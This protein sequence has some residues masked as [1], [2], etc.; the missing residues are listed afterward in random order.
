MLVLV[1]LCLA[2]RKRV[3]PWTEDLNAQNMK[4]RDVV[5]AAITGRH[6]SHA[7]AA[8]GSLQDLESA[9]IVIPSP[10]SGTKYWSYRVREDGS[11]RLAF[12][13]S[14]MYPCCYYDSRFREW[15]VDA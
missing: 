9:G 14:S 8:P 4:N 1:A 2:V 15:P 12:G 11:C 10:V 7:G 13:T 6:D 3:E 5:L